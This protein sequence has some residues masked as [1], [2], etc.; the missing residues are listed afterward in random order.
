MFAVRRKISAHLIGDTE[1]HLGFVHMDHFCPL[2]MEYSISWVPH[3][4]NTS[5]CIEILIVACY[6]FDS[7][8]SKEGTKGLCDVPLPP[9]QLIINGETELLAIDSAEMNDRPPK[10]AHLNF[11]RI[12]KLQP[13]FDCA[14]FDTLK[15][16][17]SADAES[18][19]QNKSCRWWDII[20]VKHWIQ[21]AMVIKDSSYSCWVLVVGV[22]VGQTWEKRKTQSSP[23]H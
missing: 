16:I 23:D 8:P 3:K 12:L 13:C 19:V 2:F 1:L 9:L 17:P 7:L 18:W 21:A 4:G 5:W 11:D 15:V 10:R 6:L 14:F 20:G 22:L